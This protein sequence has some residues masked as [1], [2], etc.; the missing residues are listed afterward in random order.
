[1][2]ADPRYREASAHVARGD[3]RRAAELLAPLV[4]ECP[5]VDVLALGA[6]VSLRFG[7]YAEACELA[8]GASAAEGQ[9]DPAAL[10]RYVRLLRRLEMPAELERLLERH[11][12]STL[13]DA[14]LPE[15][16]LLASSASLFDVASRLSDRMLG[17]LP[18]S[19][20]AQYVAGL[21]AMFRGERQSSLQHLDRATAIEPRMGNAHWLV[22]M[23]AD[24]GSAAAHVVAMRRAV[25]GV[26]PGSE[27]EAYLRFSLHRRLHSLQR[28]EEAWTELDRGLAI[29]RRL[30]PFDA[31]ADHALF[32]ALR[33][34]DGSAIA[35]GPGGVSGA[36]MIF[37]VG[38]FRSGTSLIERVLTGHP[39][40]VDGGETYQFTAAMREAADQDGTGVIDLPLFARAPRIDYARVGERMAAY[41]TWRKGG[42]ARLTE[43]LPSNHLLLPWILRALPDAKIVH[44]RRDARDTCFSNLRTLFRGAAAYSNDAMDMARH[45][46]AYEALMAHWHRAMPGCIL[47]VQYADFVADPARQAERLL[48]FCGLDFDPR[49]LDLAAAR[50]HTTTASAGELRRG[51]LRNRGDDW[52][53]Y[54]AHLAPMLDL[55]DRA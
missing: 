1:M 49:V 26:V 44:L 23:Q 32:D 38:M 7:A 4:R 34:T 54:A 19:A 3:W 55:L 27:V 18:A 8:R 15:L 2:Q 40:V 53:H 10:M 41:A 5:T 36:G 13:P 21:L 47:D 22:A 16:T 20:D 11:D 39:D 30:D 31:S 9:L 29:A 17:R 46:R 50:G 45:Y 51:L 14:V 42:K 33:A 35:S 24:A 12:V 48:A 25:P 43:K 6:D 28:Y 52:R 37:V